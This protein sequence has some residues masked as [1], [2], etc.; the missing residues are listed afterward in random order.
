MHWRSGS[1]MG[2]EWEWCGNGMGGVW[3]T[4][5]D[6]AT[7]QLTIGNNTGTPSGTQQSVV[8]SVHCRS[9]YYWYT[10]TD[11]QYT[12]SLSS[13]LALDCSVTQTGTD[14]QY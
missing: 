11:V 4:C 12:A 9:V 8:G 5:S 13:S 1:G 6:A 3:K 14:W 7:Q 2:V 10:A